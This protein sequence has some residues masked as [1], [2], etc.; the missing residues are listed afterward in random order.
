[1]WDADRSS[2]S[3]DARADVVCSVR[4]EAQRAAAQA[5]TGAGRRWRRH[6][7][8]GRAAPTRDCCRRDAIEAAAGC[9]LATRTPSRVRSTRCC[10]APFIDL[11]AASH[12][13]DVPEAR[14]GLGRTA[15]IA[16]PRRWSAAPLGHA[17]GETASGGTSSGTGPD[18]G[19]EA[20]CACRPPPRRSLHK[21]VEQG[22]SACEP[23][24]NARAAAATDADGRTAEEDHRDHRR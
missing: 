10:S 19:A 20:R 15:G 2:A 7:H 21:R 8:D 16:H 9:G 1:M 5:G 24:A 6:A 23:S 17:F 3:V 4:G 14:Y 13:V 11:A 18:L 12:A 22:A